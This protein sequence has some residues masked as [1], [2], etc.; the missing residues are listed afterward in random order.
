MNR[1]HF[2]TRLLAAALSS[3]ARPVLGGNDPSGPQGNPADTVRDG[4]KKL[5][6]LFWCAPIGNWLDRPGNDLRGH[7][8]GRVNPP[9][10]SCAN[11]V[12]LMVDFM[13]RTGSQEYETRIAE[14]H[15]ANRDLG[16]RLPE[17]AAA[18]KQQG[19]WSE[20]DE[21]LLAKKRAIVGTERVHGL[22]FRNEYL[23]DSGWWGIAWAK[24]H[25]RSGRPGYLVS[26]KAIH[27]H[28]A[29]NWRNEGGVSW[30]EDPDKRD[31]NAI[32]NSLFVVLSAKLYLLTRDA[33]YLDWAVKTLA[34][35][36]EAKLFDGSGIVDRPGHQGD[37]WTYNQGV[38]LGG[39]TALH[40][41]TRDQAY[42]DEAAVTCEAI[43]D[44]SGLVLSN[45]IIVEKLGM[46]G[47]DPAM[48]KGIFARLLAEL[49]RVLKAA[50][51]HPT[52][53]SKIAATLQA[54]AESL[55]KTP[56]DKD[57]LYPADWDNRPEKRIYNFNSQAS[58]LLLLAARLG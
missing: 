47:W 45:R 15:A 17:I 2:S 39:L 56:R 6:D 31:P 14:I 12:E 19:P 27:A 58:A 57:G 24:A 49:G 41:A 54:S 5:D 10:W 25:A 52:V 51:V 35:E 32:T 28:M 34:W 20:R 46:D 26:A 29:A 18:L 53:V 22:E 36:K 50:K 42:L 33:T 21:R 9:W 1:R 8:E 38:Y 44:R 40:Q 13:D 4:L 3:A 43:L 55:V 7:F 30:A 37:Y 48:F 11:V 23:D 16:S